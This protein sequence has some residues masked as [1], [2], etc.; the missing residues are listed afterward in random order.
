MTS[1]DSA[2]YLFS[3]IMPV[4]NKREFLR[5]AVDSVVK[6]TIGFHNIQLIM[7]DDGSTDGSRDICAAI[8]QEHSDNVV[9]IS[10]ENQGVS[11]ARNHG[12]EQAKGCYVNFFDADD[13][14]DLG[15]FEAVLRM[16]E[17]H[18]GEI[19]MVM[20]RLVQF[21]ASGPF[22]HVLNYKYKANGVVSLLEHPDYIQSMIGNCFIK[23][24]ALDKRRF[25]EGIACAEDT[26]LVN[27]ILLD[28]CAYGVLNNVTYRYR[29]GEL[30]STS[31]RSTHYLRY[32]DNNLVCSKLYEES[33]K[34]YGFIQPF[35]LQTALY[36]LCWQVFTSPEELLSDAQKCE[37]HKAIFDIL[38]PI[39]VSVIREGRWLNADKRFYLLALKCGITDIKA[40]DKLPDIV[41]INP[42]GKTYYKGSFALDLNSLNLVNIDTLRRERDELLIEGRSYGASLDPHFKMKISD[43]LSNWQMYADL[44][45]DPSGTVYGLSGETALSCVRFS[46]RIPVSEKPRR[47]LVFAIELSD[48]MVIERPTI[49]YGIYGKLTGEKSY[50]VCGD[51]IVK[52][53]GG[54]EIKIMP[55][56]MRTHAASEL[57]KDRWILNRKKDLTAKQRRHLVFIRLAAQIYKKLKRKPVWIF[58]DREYKA[59]DSA[60]AL[61]SY[62][63]QQNSAKDV[64]MF[65]ALE[66]R[67]DDYS[68]VAKIGKVIEPY[69]TAFQIRFLAADKL[70]SGHHDAAVT[71]PFGKQGKY[72]SSL[73][74]FL[75]YNL[76]HGTLQGD[77]SKQLNKHVRPIYRFIVSAWMEQK[78][79]VGDAYGFSE[80]EVV[81]AGMCRYDAY[82]PGRTQKKVIF[83][84]TWRANLAGKIIPGTR[85]REYM[86][87]FEE[88]D[89]CRFYNQL[90]NDER[91]IQLLKKHGFTGEFY[92]HPNYEKQ[93]AC[94][95][96]N[97]TVKVGDASADYT[98]VL[99]E[100]A[101]LVSDY[102]GVAFDFAYMRKPVVYCHFDDLFSGGHS[103]QASYFD[104]ERDGFGPVC[105]DGN[106][107]IDEIERLLDAGCEMAEEYRRR[108]DSFFVHSD[109]QN[110]ARVLDA[111]M[112][113]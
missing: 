3:V 83:L 92:V 58:I 64:S 12:I 61:F 56:R 72:V 95:H 31:S 59:G 2:K 70:F 81:P 60:E 97:D 17:A 84:P 69:S 7:V 73:Y 86:P 9:L 8:A 78:A 52:R 74:Q 108:A 44:R 41:K 38:K 43:T 30:G 45:P 100:G 79:L 6:Q 51:I 105:Y 63:R 65:F 91:L 33:E 106:E 15:A 20:T 34:R 19:D 47:N 4:Y 90:I 10:Q 88:S 104:Y 22:E 110:C 11:A 96:G 57:R 29:K 111:V 14:W 54:K 107:V 89:Y 55:Y 85:R 25:E 94:F 46:F 87:N 39:P 27:G 113:S 112:E 13:I 103:Y 71:N 5:E 50:A 102:S 28:K 1:A 40:V 24:S 53:G 76:S 36:E 109:R 98:D 42:N 80:D 77:L 32:R 67:S 75:F 66:K 62:A 16:F 93:V 48:G 101:I 37:W 21:N 99:S 23:K 68:R 26:L 49:R 82:D 35:I 18:E